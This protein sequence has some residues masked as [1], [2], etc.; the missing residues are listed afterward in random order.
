MATSKIR[1][2]RVKVYPA[3]NGAG[4]DGQ[5]Y[6]Y[7]FDVFNKTFLPGKSFE[8][9]ERAVQF[10]RHEQERIYT[11]QEAEPEL[12]DLP[13]LSSD[14]DLIAR[15]D[16]DSEYRK[17]LLRDLTGDARARGKRH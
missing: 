5:V 15:V 9:T 8:S 13:F 14:P 2:A 7:V 16:R 17:S 10:Q 12:F 1:A 4:G 11:V 3:P 6:V